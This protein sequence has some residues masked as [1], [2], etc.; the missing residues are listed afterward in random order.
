M[1]NWMQLQLEGKRKSTEL[2]LQS[3]GL[4]HLAW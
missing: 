1:V 3:D 4:L 2:Q